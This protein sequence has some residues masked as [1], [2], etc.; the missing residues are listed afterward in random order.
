MKITSF[1]DKIEIEEKKDFTII[2]IVNYKF[3][4]KFKN[5]IALN[6]NSLVTIQAYIDS[7]L[8]RNVLK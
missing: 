6:N 2:R 4:I 3:F 7:I 5:E 1:N 8:L